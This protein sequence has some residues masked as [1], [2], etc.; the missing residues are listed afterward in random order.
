MSAPQQALLMT[1]SAVSLSNLE[2]VSNATSTATTITIPSGFAVGDI[3]I[4][5]QYAR[6]SG[7]YTGGTPTGWTLVANN[8]TTTGTGGTWGHIAYKV[9][10]SGD[11]G[12]SITGTGGGQEQAKIII[13]FRPNAPITTVTISSLNTHAAATDPPTQ[14]ITDPGTKPFIAFA[15]YVC[16][17][18]VTNRTSNATMTEVASAI[19]AATEQYMRYIRYNVGDTSQ[20]ITV[21]YDD[22]GDNNVLQSFA[23]AVS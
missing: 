2:F 22:S 1:N 12:S 23:L 21:D 19:A 14:T 16:G 17:Q 6:G 13:G 8:R 15:H 7:S 18:G 5:F 9:L 10:A 20:S 11:P 3:A 4:L